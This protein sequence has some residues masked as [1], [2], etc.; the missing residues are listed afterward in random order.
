MDIAL[1][2]MTYFYIIS[3]L[4]DPGKE[5]VPYRGSGYFDTHN[6]CVEELFFWAC[7]NTVAIFFAFIKLMSYLRVFEKMVMLVSLL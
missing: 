1:F 3:R 2:L 7:M 6:P 5:I 4:N